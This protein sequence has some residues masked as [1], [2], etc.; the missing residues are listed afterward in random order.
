[1]TQLNLLNDSGRYVI[2]I[3]DSIYTQGQMR[4]ALIDKFSRYSVQPIKFKDGLPQERPSKTASGLHFPGDTNP[5]SQADYFLVCAK[6][7]TRI[8]KDALS[9]THLVGVA[10]TT[11]TDDPVFM[12]YAGKV[13]AAT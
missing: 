13:V 9:G 3:D 7:F 11:Y 1:M 8:E 4:T 2:E 6:T 5:W 10:W 12:R